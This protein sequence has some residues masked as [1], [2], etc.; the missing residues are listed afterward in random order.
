MWS[1]KEKDNTENIKY[2]RLM[3]GKKSINADLCMQNNCTGVDFGLHMN[4][5]NEL[6]EDWKVF[7]KKFIPLYLEKHQDNSKVRA[8]MACAMIYTIMTYA[9]AI[10]GERNSWIK[11][12]LNK[13]CLTL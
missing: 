6:V 10:L 4:L 8:G 5:K 3:L 7:N 12:S 9:K 11:Y 1:R 13:S 2:Y